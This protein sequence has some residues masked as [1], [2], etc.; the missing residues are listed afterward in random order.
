LFGGPSVSDS[1]HNDGGVTRTVYRAEIGEPWPGADAGTGYGTLVDGGLRV[2]GPV[3]MR[4]KPILVSRGNQNGYVVCGSVDTTEGAC[5]F[6][7]DGNPP[8]DTTFNLVGN[9][10]TFEVTA[11]GAVAL[12]IMDTPG[13]WLYLRSGETYGAKPVVEI[14]RRLDVGP[15]GFATDASVQ[16][17]AS[18]IGT[19]AADVY[20]EGTLRV[21]VLSGADGG[22]RTK[23]CLCTSDGALTPVWQ[24]VATG[25]LGTSTACGSE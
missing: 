19:C 13:A 7:Q 20:T 25:T 5:W 22:K 24:N 12:G 10:S 3:E 1:W 14:V 6:T 17:R 21:D 11:A 16:L 18:A 15:Q 23:L 9:G 4:G 8:T 2:W